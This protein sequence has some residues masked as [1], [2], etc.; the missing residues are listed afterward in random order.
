MHTLTDFGV[1]T[2][3]ELLSALFVVGSGLISAEKNNNTI[4]KIIMLHKS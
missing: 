2:G 1:V 4:I 3:P